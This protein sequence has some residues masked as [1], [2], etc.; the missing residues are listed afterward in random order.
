MLHRGSINCEEY[1]YLL[2]ASYNMF[3]LRYSVTVIYN[4]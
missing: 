3:Y 2:W 1:V 4:W